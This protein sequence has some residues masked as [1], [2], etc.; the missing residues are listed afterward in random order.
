MNVLIAYEC[1]G[2]V[3]EAFRSRGH[4]AYS[5]DLKESKDN[6]PYHF[7]DRANTIM[8][9]SDL[10]VKEDSWDLIIMH[11]PC[12]ALAVSGN[13]SYAKGKPKYKEREESIIETLTSFS[14]AKS[15]AWSVCMENPV[16]VLPIKPNQYIQPWQ[17]GHPESKKTGLWLYN[18]KPLKETNNVKDVYDSLPKKEQQKIYYMPH[19]K[20]RSEK[21]SITYQGIADAMAEQW[22]CK[23]ENIKQFIG[24]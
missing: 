4:N 16:G 8:M 2:K 5:V 18:L 24:G 20:D 19:T 17:F 1:Y 22:G 23:E 3:R 9:H 15:S 14:V 7:V 13:A 12:I 11:P 10:I 6:S 21:R